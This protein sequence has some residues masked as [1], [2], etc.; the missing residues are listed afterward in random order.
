VIPEAEPLAP[1]SSAEVS[2]SRIA[3]YASI[4][5]CGV[6]PVLTV[7][8]LFA[9]A[10][11]D[12]S[13]AM[14][15]GQFYRGAEA[16]LAGDNPYPAGDASLI[17]SARPY[18]YP[19][20]PAILLL[21][22]TMLPLRVAELLVMASLLGVVV[23]ILWLLDVR[24]WRC[25]GIAFLWPPVISAIQ[26][27]NPTLWF[28]LAAAVVWRY[29]DRLVP[30]SAGVGVTLAVKFV[31]WPLV[32]WLA[33]T[34][35]LA[36]AG[37]A[38]LLAAGV[39]FVSWA[40]IGF[41]GMVEYPG[42]L[43]RLEDTVGDDAYTIRMVALDLGAPPPIARTLWLAIGTGL[44]AAVVLVARAGGERRAFI[45]SLA[46]SLALSPLVWLHYFALLLVVVALAQ[47]A[48]GLVWFV[49][50]LMF[51]SPG[52]GNPTLFETT[53][54]LFAAAV[55]VALALTSVPRAP[56]ATSVGRVGLPPAPV[57]ST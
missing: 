47:P 11:Q 32:V 42:L 36:A 34:R 3:R 55:T 27:S 7:A 48:L 6:L 12:H 49:P 40:A 57:E 56:S 44:L 23:A 16:I 22:L 39:L 31:L 1:S 46:A 52:S 25:Y 24:D 43:R 5:F 33:A 17:A 13:V 26:T 29:R 4:A 2:L 15:F 14:D 37:L 35:R 50:L 20:F 38:C 51:G 21:P 9:G 10:N 8:V 30:A 18:V 53:T 28:A 45:L 41:T 19:P 54:A